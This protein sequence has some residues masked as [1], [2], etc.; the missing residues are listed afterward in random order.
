MNVHLPQ[1]VIKLKHLTRLTLAVEKS[2]RGLYELLPK[3][4]LVLIWPIEGSS[5]GPLISI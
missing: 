3:S 1:S 5:R 4:R 2:V